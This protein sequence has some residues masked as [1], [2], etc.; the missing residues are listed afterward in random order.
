MECEKRRDSC[1]VLSRPLPVEKPKS[2]AKREREAKAYWDSLT[3]EQEAWVLPND[4][5][6]PPQAGD[7]AVCRSAVTTHRS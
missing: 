3:L 5:V 1:F 7:S 2:R 6:P 4:D